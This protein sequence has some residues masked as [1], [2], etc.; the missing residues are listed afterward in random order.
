MDP[1]V[2]EIRAFGFNFAPVQWAFCN[3]QI[4]SIA[5]NTALFSILGTFYGGNGTSTFALPNLQGR[6]PMHWGSGN[7]GLNT[8]IGEPLGESEVTLTS[9]EM[10]RHSHTIY[11]AKQG[12]SDERSAGPNQN[13]QSYLAQ[14][15][16]ALLYQAAPVTPSASFS[17]SAISTAGGSLPHENMQPYLC[18]NFCI[19]LYGI[20]PSRN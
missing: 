18:I 8:V 14:V 9:N 17:N 4:L 20:Y 5:Q 15:N 1:Y 6:S 12:S 10:P 19:S 2:G 16:G 7:T 3:G 11:A 13:G